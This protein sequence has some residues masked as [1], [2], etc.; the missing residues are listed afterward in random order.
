MTQTS[1][2]SYTRDAQQVVWL[3]VDVP[4]AKVN[5]LKAEA[6]DDVAEILQQLEVNPPQAVILY[7]LK[8]DHFIAGAD[9]AMIDACES[10]EQVKD[11]AKRGQQVFQRLANLP[12]PVVAA[13]HGACLGGGLELALA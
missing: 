1:G 8:T 13:I 9:V 11:I 10:A 2:F 6:F 3:A 5:T 4:N 7:S 12:C